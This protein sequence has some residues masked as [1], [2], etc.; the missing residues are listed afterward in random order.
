MPAFRVD[1]IDSIVR[2]WVKN[3]LQD[4]ENVMDGLRG[5][6]EEN[7][8]TH[9]ALYDRQ[10]LIQGQLDD[11]LRQQEKLVDLYISGDFDKD[12]LLE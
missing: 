11:L 3:L 10:D 7:R 6:Q 5:M 9:I 2:Q 12:V 4:P 8:R 1:M